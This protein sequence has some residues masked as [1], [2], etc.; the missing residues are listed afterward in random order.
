MSESHRLSNIC[1]GHKRMH[2]MEAGTCDVG[3]TYIFLRDANSGEC[4][5]AGYND[6]Q[7]HR[8]HVVAGK[9]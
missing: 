7:A 5:S 9:A 4:W 2:V 8:V 6:G 1:D 3:G